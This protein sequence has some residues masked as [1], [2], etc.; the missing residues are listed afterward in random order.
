MWIVDLIHGR[1][2]LTVSL[3]EF[4]ITK[5]RKWWEQLLIP[6]GWWN[7]KRKCLVF[8]KSFLLSLML[9]RTG[10]C[11]K[12]WLITLET[13]QT[14]AFVGLTELLRRS[15]ID[16]VLVLKASLMT[17]CRYLTLLVAALLR[18]VFRLG[19]MEVKCLLHGG[20]L[21]SRVLFQEVIMTKTS[22]VMTIQWNNVTIIQNTLNCQNATKS[23]KS[24][25][26]V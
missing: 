22:Y 4:L 2:G 20:G 26:N 10:Q 16:C 12:P 11:V 5:S 24:L 23:S 6:S 25:L 1:R 9:A 13:S 8:L 14:L 15:M 21:L 3:K 19:W 18:I 17:Y 7:L